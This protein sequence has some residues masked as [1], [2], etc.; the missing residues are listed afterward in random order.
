MLQKTA[1]PYCMRRS[2][3]PGAQRRFIVSRRHSGPS[4]ASRRVKSSTFSSTPAAVSDSSRSGYAW[5]RAGKTS[6]TCLGP[7][8][9]HLQEYS[10]NVEA[11]AGKTVRLA[12]LDDDP[13]PDCY[14][15]CSGFQMLTDDRTLDRAFEKEVHQF[16]REH[17]LKSLVRF[18][19]QHYLAMS[20]A[21]NSFSELRLGNCELLY[22]S[23]FQHFRSKGFKLQEPV[24]KLHA[25]VFQSQASFNDFL[26]TKVSP[27]VTG[28]YIFRTNRLAMYDF[29]TNQEFVVTKRK[30][31]ERG[32]RIGP[33]LERERYMEA[34]TRQSDEFRRGHNI[35]TIMHEAAHQLSFNC[36]LLNRSADNPL[37][38][39]E[40]LA[41][42]CEATNQGSW[43]GIGEPNPERLASLSKALGAKTG[44]LPLT[45][46]IAGDKWISP[47]GEETSVLQGY[48]Q[49]WALFRW[50]ME[51]KPA[52]LREYLAVL[53][54]RSTPENR[55]ADFQH[56]F[57]RDLPAV[58]KQYEEYVKRLVKRYP[59][60]QR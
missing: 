43:Q 7:K 58:Q 18:E 49:S 41:C 52:K 8:K 34:V 16:E 24:G 47:T 37:W 5:I 57:G 54:K 33:Q 31:E 2:K 21:D 15:V 29:G 11:V 46:M 53:T 17:H 32:Q 12:L 20:N 56:A 9:G 60:P 10:W 25:V 36:G 3:F 35:G 22:S 55:L 44:L 28:I 45:T 30:A 26:G 19:S 14:I 59:P 40:G 48:G 1:G 50:L 6:I 23:F 13:R 51:E 27:F 4:Q 38:L 42:Y 39:A